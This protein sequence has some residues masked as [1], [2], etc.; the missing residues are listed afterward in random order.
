MEVNGW[1]LFR[2]WGLALNSGNLQKQQECQSS[3][4]PAQKSKCKKEVWAIAVF[5]NKIFKCPVVL[6]DFIRIPLLQPS[7]PTNSPQFRQSDKAHKNGHFWHPK[8]W[9]W[10][11]EKKVFPRI[12]MKIH[13]LQKTGS[14]LVNFCL[15]GPIFILH[16]AIGGRHPVPCLSTQIT[17]RQGTAMY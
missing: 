17:E 15:S 1:P 5:Y 4:A 7:I 10:V 13:F 16:P 6:D 2:N 14:K 9:T 11:P 3:T 12:H 8:K